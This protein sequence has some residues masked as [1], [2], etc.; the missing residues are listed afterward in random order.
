MERI[1]LGVITK[2]Q[3]LKGAF[4]VRLNISN[5]KK[6]KKLKSVYIDNNTYAIE[7][8]SIRES[9]VI[10]KL[11]NIDSCEQ[12]EL[13][14][15]KSIW[16]DMEVEVSENLDLIGFEARVANLVGKIM[17]INNYGSKDIMSIQ[18]DKSCMVPVIEGLIASVDEKNKIVNFDKEIFEQ[19]VVYENWYTN[20]ISWNVWTFES[21]HF[22]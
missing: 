7:S 10:F 11:E 14:R 9:F 19:V 15:N 2:P 17:D 8:V 21:R 18:F 20:I 3:A 4:R 16:A 5:P 6:L 1:K 22:G 12:T 13:L